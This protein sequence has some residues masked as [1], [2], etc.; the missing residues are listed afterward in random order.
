MK[1]Y[2]H[3]R[4]NIFKK[5]L[6]HG[7]PTSMEMFKWRMQVYS[8]NYN[9]RFVSLCLVSAAR[10]EYVRDTVAEHSGYMDAKMRKEEAKKCIS[11]AFGTKG[12]QKSTMN[13][14]FS[15]GLSPYH[16]VLV[17]DLHHNDGRVVSQLAGLPEQLHVVKHQQLVPRGAQRL[18]QDLRTCASVELTA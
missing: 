14:C 15:Q 17:V 16:S 5:K 1:M 11:R 4:Q 10:N 13:S 8:C 3:F 6:F 12:N 2:L 18:A 9:M 7:L